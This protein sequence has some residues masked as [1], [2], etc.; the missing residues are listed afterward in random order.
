MVERRDYWSRAAV[1]ARVVKWVKDHRGSQS[2]PQTDPSIAERILKWLA[3]RGLATND[4]GTWKP[5]PAMARPVKVITCSHLNSRV[6]K[7]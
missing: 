4:D 2:P 5:T 6:E 3:L 1:V 7:S